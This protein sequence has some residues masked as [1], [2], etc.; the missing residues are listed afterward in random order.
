MNNL[1]KNVVKFVA[2]TAPWL[3]PFPPAFSSPVRN[4]DM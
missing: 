4:V 3:A 1:E 2:K